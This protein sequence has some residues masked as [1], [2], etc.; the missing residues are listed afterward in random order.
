MRAADVDQDLPFECW[1]IQLNTLPC[2][3]ASFPHGR[4][5]EEQQLRQ[6]CAWRWGGVG[7]C[8]DR[9]TIVHA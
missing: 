1:P 3:C 6:R 7:T 4:S 9:L 5:C 8:R 2:K